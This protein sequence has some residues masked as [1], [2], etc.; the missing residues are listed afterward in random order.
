MSDPIALAALLVAVFAALAAL[1]AALRSG[2][3]SPA[4]PTSTLQAQRVEDQLQSVVER[5]ARI[6]AAQQ[7]I[8]RLR[9]PMDELLSVFQNKQARGQYGEARLEE[10]VRDA[11]P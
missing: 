5:L 1:V 7:G 8:D 11:L 2:R 10:I 6:D 9:E 3:T 4:D